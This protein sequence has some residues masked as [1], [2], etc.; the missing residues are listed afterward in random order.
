MTKDTTIAVTL[1]PEG[2]AIF[3]EAMT[4]AESAGLNPPRFEELILSD[5]EG[6]TARQ[7]NWNEQGNDD[8]FTAGY[9]LAAWKRGV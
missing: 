4:L 9:A 7:H 3:N 5:S 8:S 6:S 1:D 2:Y